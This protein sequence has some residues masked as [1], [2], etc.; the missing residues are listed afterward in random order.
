[1]PFFPKKI[2]APLKNVI[3]LNL[4]IDTN[5]LVYERWL[6]LKV[7]Y[8]AAC[9]ATQLATRSNAF[10]ITKTHIAYACESTS[11]KYPEP[12]PKMSLQEI[13]NCYHILNLFHG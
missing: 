1:M 2:V 4:Y 9:Q 7:W 5:V 6:V 3:A 13:L 8:T 12:L 10:D 11:N